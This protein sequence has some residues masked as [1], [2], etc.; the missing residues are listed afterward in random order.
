MVTMDD[1][2]RALI[3][4]F[5]ADLDGMTEDQMRD[6]LSRKQQEL[7][8]YEAWIEALSACL[9]QLNKHKGNLS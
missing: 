8:D 3:K 9:R 7:E 5:E 6:E 4:E 1:V 2:D